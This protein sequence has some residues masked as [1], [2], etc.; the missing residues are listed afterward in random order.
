LQIYRLFM[1]II[2]RE[3][4]LVE[5]DTVK[6]REKFVGVTSCTKGMDETRKREKVVCNAVHKTKDYNG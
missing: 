2:H 3:K 4:I 5:V 6:A 1:S